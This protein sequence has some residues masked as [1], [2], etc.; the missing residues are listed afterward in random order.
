MDTLP[1]TI[2]EQIIQ[3]FGRCFHYKDTVEAFL[4]SAGVSQELANKYKH[5]PKFVW[6]RKVLNDL[7]GS[8]DG[9][10]IQRKILTE[11]CRLRN[12]PEDVPDRNAALDTLRKLK[13]LANDHQIEYEI[14]K[15]ETA[16][17]N[18]TAKNKLKIIEERNAK[19]SNLNAKFIEGIQS[20]NRQKAGYDLEDILKELFALSEV[21]YKR[22]YRTETQQIDG[23]FKFD[24]FNYLL[25]AKWRQDQPNEAEIGSF[26]RKVNTK[27][28]ATRGVFISING[29]RQEVINE[30]SG[31]GTNIILMSGEDIIHILEG[32]VELKEALNIK[33]ECAS[34]YGTAYTKVF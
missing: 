24:G 4:R 5:E 34:Q 18:E 11:L 17:R 14:V 16:F 9:R 29:F 13:E 33:I 7:E 30:F 8:D 25:E 10:V 6:A 21:D 3:C 27:L 19:L 32:R 20:R 12:V 1:Y 28:D 31:H 22:S 26:Q 2:K 23:H 15:K